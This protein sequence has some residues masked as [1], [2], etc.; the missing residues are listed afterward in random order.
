MKDKF[1]HCEDI[2]PNSDTEKDD[3]DKICPEDDCGSLYVS[4]KMFLKIMYK[5]INRQNDNQQ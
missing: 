2:N 1:N 5:V 4:D 3:F